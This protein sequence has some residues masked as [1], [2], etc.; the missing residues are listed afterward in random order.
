MC[1]RWPARSGRRR[2][3]RRGAWT[4]RSRCP[5]TSSTNTGPRALAA[6]LYIG[7]RSPSVS[8]S[9]RWSRGS[10]EPV[11]AEEAEHVVRA[12]HRPATRA[13]LLGGRR[14]CHRDRRNRLGRRNGL[15][16]GRRTRDL[17]FDSHSSGLNRRRAG[18]GR[19][20]PHGLDVVARRGQRLP[21][22]EGA[23]GPGGAAG[24]GGSGGPRGHEGEKTPGQTERG[25]G[26]GQDGGGGGGGGRRDPGPGR[27]E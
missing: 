4:T 21:A 6:Y 26:A 22:R 8:R 25:G 9:V 1:G 5:R 23:A 14:L 20:R 17:R 10:A 19:G 11:P 15:E 24:R 7:V 13:T 3:T 18:W 27:R 2:S 16:W 12:D